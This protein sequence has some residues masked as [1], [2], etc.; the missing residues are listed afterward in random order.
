MDDKTLLNSDMH[1]I[2]KSDAISDLSFL[3]SKMFATHKIKDKIEI[4]DC[5]I[6][7]TVVALFLLSLSILPRTN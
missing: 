1:T 2:R 7:Y 3:L 5:K 4:M 6:K